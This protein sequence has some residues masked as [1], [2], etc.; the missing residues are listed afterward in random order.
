[1]RIHTFLT[2]LSSVVLFGFIDA[3]RKNDDIIVDF[4]N[5]YFDLE[6][7]EG[8]FLWDWFDVWREDFEHAMWYWHLLIAVGVCVGCVWLT[9]NN[10]RVAQVCVYDTGTAICSDVKDLFDRMSS[11]TRHFLN[12][13]LMTTDLPLGTT[14]VLVVDPFFVPGAFPDESVET[15]DAREIEIA[16]D[17]E[18]AATV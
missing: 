11:S 4:L 13:L 3:C 8:Q 6:A 12:D 10:E 15:W 14:G 2:V 5:A 18:E 9:V 7:S 16:S 17:N 1:M